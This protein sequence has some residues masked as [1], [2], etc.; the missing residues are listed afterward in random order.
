MN[1]IIWVPTKGPSQ[2]FNVVSKRVVWPQVDFEKSV[3]LKMTSFN[4]ITLNSVH[5]FTFSNFQFA[6]PCKK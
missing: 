3:Y 2:K 4:D 5:F 6:T 1:K